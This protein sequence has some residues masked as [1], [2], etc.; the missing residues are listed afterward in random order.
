MYRTSDGEPDYTKSRFKIGLDGGGGFL[1]M[2]VQCVDDPKTA[3]S[4]NHVLLLAMMA[5]PENYHNLKFLFSLSPI[6]DFVAK[7]GRIQ[8]S[9]D[10]KV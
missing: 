10:C 1:K 2:T 3:N 8:L 9:G 6:S 5:A 7:A 4:V